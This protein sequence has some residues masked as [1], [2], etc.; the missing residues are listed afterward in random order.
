MSEE[1]LPALVPA[2]E[3][4]DA[5]DDAA[6]FAIRRVREVVAVTQLIH[7]EPPAD[8]PEPAKK[9]NVTWQIGVWSGPRQPSRRALGMSDM[10]GPQQARPRDAARADKP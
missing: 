7:P 10:G 2:A 9:A 8:T 6:A 1:E 3:V 5:D 4:E